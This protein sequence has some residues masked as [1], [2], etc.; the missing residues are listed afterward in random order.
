MKRTRSRDIVDLTGDDVRLTDLPND[1]LKLIVTGGAF[2]SSPGHLSFLRLARVCKHFARLFPERFFTV[3]VK[4][5]YERLERV[6][7]K[8]D[9]NSEHLWDLIPE[10]RALLPGL[11]RCLLSRFCVHNLGPS[12]MPNAITPVTTEMGWYPFLEPPVTFSWPRLFFLYAQSGKSLGIDQKEC[13]NRFW[14]TWSEQNRKQ[15]RA[16]CL[17]VC[18]H[19]PWCELNCSMIDFVVVTCPRLYERERYFGRPRVALSSTIIPHYPVAICLSLFL[20]WFRDLTHAHAKGPFACIDLSSLRTVFETYY[21]M[22]QLTSSIL[23]NG[24]KFNP[25]FAAFKI[26]GNKVC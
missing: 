25:M 1:M 21:T 22:L 4:H 12:M 13:F 26:C 23:H 24:S 2:T 14:I 5:T 7:N 8:W 9:P 16:F 3:F 6:L 11:P 18:I 17:F 19:A 20:F 10:Q 15:A